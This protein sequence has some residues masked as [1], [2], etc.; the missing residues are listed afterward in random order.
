MF[1]SN[2]SQQNL[3]CRLMTY[4]VQK[5]SLKCVII[6]SVIE[7]FFFFKTASHTNKFLATE[8]VSSGKF[9]FYRDKQTKMSYILYTSTIHGRFW[10]FYTEYT[11]I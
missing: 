11:M 3:W 6:L 8:S 4:T 1:W 5:I 7:F 9:Y 10:S 2:F